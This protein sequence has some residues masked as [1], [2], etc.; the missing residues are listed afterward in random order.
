MVPASGNSYGIRTVLSAS[1][2]SP[3]AQVVMSPPES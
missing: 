3:Q 2:P 1:S